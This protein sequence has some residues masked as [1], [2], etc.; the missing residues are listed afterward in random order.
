M[1]F[2]AL[3]EMPPK[4]KSRKP[5]GNWLRKYHPDVSKETDAES[6]MQSINVAYDAKQ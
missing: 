3:T 2:L 6:K 5:T 1:K 4:I